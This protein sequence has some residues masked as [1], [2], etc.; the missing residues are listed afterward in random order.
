M[1]NTMTRSSATTIMPPDDYRCDIT[2]I[3]QKLSCAFLLYD[4]VCGKTE[5]LW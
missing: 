3:A 2:Y 4:V 1:L 5:P